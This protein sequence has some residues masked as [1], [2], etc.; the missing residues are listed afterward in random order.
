MTRGVITS[1]A[2]NRYPSSAARDIWYVLYPSS[3]ARDVGAPGVRDYAA[4]DYGSTYRH[5]PL[6][7]IAPIRTLLLPSLTVLICAAP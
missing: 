6:F 5:R 2:A 3:L 1:D 7:H 4:S